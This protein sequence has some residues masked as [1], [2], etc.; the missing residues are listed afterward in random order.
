MLR[1][2]TDLEKAFCRETGCPTDLAAGAR[3]DQ[4]KIVRRDPALIRGDGFSADRP[5]LGQIEA[6][7]VAENAFFGN[8]IIK[9]ANAFA[10][11]KATGIRHVIH[12]GIEFMADTCEVDGVRFSTCT[13]AAQRR[14]VCPFYYHRTL[15]SLTQGPV[16]MASTMGALAS[17]ITLKR[18]PA[19][20]LPDDHL[21]IHIRSGDIFKQDPPHPYYA[22]PPLAFYRHV[23]GLRPWSGATLVYED[24]GNPV[25]EGLRTHLRQIGLPF[26]DQS[27]AL[28]DDL[29]TLM[30]ARHLVIA[31]G[32]FAYP[33]VAMSRTIEEVFS[34]ENYQNESQERLLWAQVVKGVKMHTVFDLEGTYRDKVLAHWEN[35]PEQ[36]QLMLDY[37]ATSL[38]TVFSPPEPVTP[39]AG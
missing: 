27:G 38:T 39:L 23:L 34:F 33:V 24:T 7:E 1:E 36:R 3:I 32:T 28:R 2:L 17:V 19:T 25:I 29:E 37:P 13:D 16:D 6:L 10:L 22:Q 14:L 20:T 11:A 5:V 30:A 15:Q 35:S 26:N 31:R 12:P 8:Y 4:A 18:P 21:M 9:L